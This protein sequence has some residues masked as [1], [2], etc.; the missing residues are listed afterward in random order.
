MNQ[1]QQASQAIG[2]KPIVPGPQEL[3]L[4]ERAEKLMAGAAERID[5]FLKGPWKGYRSFV[6]GNRPEFFGGKHP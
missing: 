5:A 3:M 2:S 6:E 4:V 1:F